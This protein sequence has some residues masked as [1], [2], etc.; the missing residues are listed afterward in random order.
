ML[1]NIDLEKMNH[2]METNKDA[3][4]IIT[5]LLKNHDAAVATIAHEIRNPMTVLYSSMQLMSSLYAET[6]KGSCVWEECMDGA[7]HMC[8][9]LDDLTELNNGNQLNRASFPLGHVLRNSAVLF[10]MSLN[11]EKSKIEEI[12]KS[13][14]DNDTILRA[15]GMVECTD[16][17]WLY[18]DMVPG[19]YELREGEPDYTG[20][21]CVIGTQIDEHALEE[22]FGIA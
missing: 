10:A 20:R 17:T 19:E 8:D 21:L 4:E 16:G 6:A 5:Q 2:L 14:V 3:K 1:T 9:L 15:K 22:L 18:F 11:F 7:R 13:F 12:L